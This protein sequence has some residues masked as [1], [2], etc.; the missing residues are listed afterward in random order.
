[1]VYEK[2]GVLAIL[3]THPYIDLV[4][5]NLTDTDA[6]GYTRDDYRVLTRA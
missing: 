5:H 1:M 2:S 4:T 3:K 6:Y